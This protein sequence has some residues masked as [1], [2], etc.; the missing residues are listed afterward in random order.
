MHLTCSEHVLITNIGRLQF[1]DSTLQ[2]MI[3]RFEDEFPETRLVPPPSD[4]SSSPPDAAAVDDILT[5]N[6]HDDSTTTDPT[7]IDEQAVL[8]TSPPEADG[9][10]PLIR[11]AS[12][13][14]RG[15]S[16]NLA[17]RQAQE[18]G[19]MHRFGQRI[20]RDILRPQ[21][22]DHAHGTTGHEEEPEH[23]QELRRRLEALKGDEIRAKVEK[24]GADATL[25]EIETERLKREMGGWKPAGGEDENEE[26][27]EEWRGRMLGDA[28][29]VVAGKT[30][31][32]ATAAT[33]TAAAAS[34][35]S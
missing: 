29:A 8:S 27:L 9:S 7:A 5:N 16:P 30:P 11:P 12:I 18:E 28:V 4:P 25:Q 23:L 35:S 26:T 20:K 3:Q 13:S 17:S 31:A 1:L 10:S 14:R 34:S 21:T 19:R 15:S 6:P 32:T 24:Y 2:R 33:T 22:E